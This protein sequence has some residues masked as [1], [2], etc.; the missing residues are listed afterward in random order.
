MILHDREEE[1]LQA[2]GEGERAGRLCLQVGAD[3]L[4][5]K[6]DSRSEPDGL[7]LPARTPPRP[8][9]AL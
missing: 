3:G 1:E 8:H 4:E 5:S 7:L 2:A 6:E 9:P